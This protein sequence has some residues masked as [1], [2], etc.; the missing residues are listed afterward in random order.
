LS[1]GQKQRI[2][3]ARAVVSNPSILLLDEA[4]SALDPHAEREVQKALDKAAVN[5][6]T[7]VIAHKLTTICHADNIVVMS[8]GEIVEQGNHQALLARGGAYSRLVEAQGLEAKVKE[9]SDELDAQD[10]DEKVEGAL[11]EEKGLLTR[12]HTTRSVVTEDAELVRQQAQLDYDTHKRRGI[13]WVIGTTIR[14][15]REMWPLFGIIFTACI[16]GGECHPLPSCMIASV[17]IVS[18]GYL[19][20]PS[21]DSGTTHR[22]LQLHRP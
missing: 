3:I 10:L 5:R 6:T 21:R 2:A 17:L 15:Q 8:A 18:S 12:V 22:C 16:A 20:R 19:S 1:G 7:I 9:E 11:D 4:T 13:L 14:Q